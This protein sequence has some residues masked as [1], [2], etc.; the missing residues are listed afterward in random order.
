M[1]TTT[2]AISL[3]YP[4]AYF[5]EKVGMENKC[6]IVPYRLIIIVSPRGEV[7]VSTSVFLSVCLS[8]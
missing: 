1:L 5:T 8:V 3:I 2:P 7:M 4:L 6:V